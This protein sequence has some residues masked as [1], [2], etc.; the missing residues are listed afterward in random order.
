M[1]RFARRLVRQDKELLL[2]PLF[3]GI[4][5]MLKAPGC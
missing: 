4:A 1:R 3:S 2:F 5:S